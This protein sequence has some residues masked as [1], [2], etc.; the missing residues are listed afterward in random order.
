MDKSYQIWETKTRLFKRDGYRCQACGKS[1]YEY[2]SPQLAHRIK[3]NEMYL[4]RYG[5]EV[6]YHDDNMGST[7]C[8]KCNAKLDLGH[9]EKLISDLAEK[10]KKKLA[11]DLT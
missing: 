5:K 4:R 3:A 8:L 7:C 6:I 2:G 11:P 1:I 9:K 10:I